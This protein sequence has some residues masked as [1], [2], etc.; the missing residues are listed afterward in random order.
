[1]TLT[2]PTWDFLKLFFVRWAEIFP[3][4]AVLEVAPASTQVP[5]SA[6]AHSREPA[7]KRAALRRGEGTILVMEDKRATFLH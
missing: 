5:T 4:K 3:E 6:S 7:R 1:M 2:E